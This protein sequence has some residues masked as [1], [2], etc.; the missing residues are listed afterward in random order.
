MSDP[1]AL[2]FDSETAGLDGGV[3][4]IAMVLIDSGFNVVWEAQSLI[5][6]EKSISEKASEIH[7]ITDHMVQF[8]PTLGEWLDSQGRPFHR[9]NQVLVAFNVSFDVRMCKAHLPENYAKSCALRMA[10]QYVPDSPDHKLQTLRAHLGLE[11]GTAHRA[12]GDVVTTINLLKYLSS[13]LSLTLA[14]LLDAGSRKYTPDDKLSFGKHK[15][16]KL[17]NLPASYVMWLLGQPDLDPD[18]RLGLRT[19][20]AAETA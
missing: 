16:M 2:L 14:Q 5:N 8:S 19:R 11:G 13:N 9:E 17:K 18:L 6:P 12:M 4:D 20:L 15:G 10:R 1:L 3:C 7:G